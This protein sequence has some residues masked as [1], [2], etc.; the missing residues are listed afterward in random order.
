MMNFLSKT[1]NSVSKMRN[2]ALKTRNSVSKLMNFAS[3][4]FEAKFDLLSNPPT[5]ESESEEES[6]AA[7]SS[8]HEEEEEEEEGSLE[9]DR[10]NRRLAAGRRIPASGDKDWS[11]IARWMRRPLFDSFDVEIGHDEVA[12]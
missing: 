2:C 8:L 7:G 9:M 11:S 5:S 6:D 3:D 4:V 12:H 10:L 1:R